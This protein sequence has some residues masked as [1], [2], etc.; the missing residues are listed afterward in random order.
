MGNFYFLDD[1]PEAIR[2]CNLLQV[3]GKVRVRA[4]TQNVTEHRFV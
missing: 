1:E 3:T 2:L 4:E